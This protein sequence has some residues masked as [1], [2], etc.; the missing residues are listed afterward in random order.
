LALMSRR[1]EALESQ[2][3]VEEIDG[4]NS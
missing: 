3:S 1:V 2:L 4:E